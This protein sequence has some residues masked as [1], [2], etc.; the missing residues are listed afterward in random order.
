MN[1]AEFFSLFEQYL[2]IIQISIAKEDIAQIFSEIDRDGDQWIA[3]AEFLEFLKIFFRRKQTRISINIGTSTIMSFAS[4]GAVGETIGHRRRAKVSNRVRKDVNSQWRNILDTNNLKSSNGLTELIR[5]QLFAIILRLDRERSFEQNKDA[6]TRLLF[7]IF[8]KGSGE[9]EFAMRK[10]LKFRK[11]LDECLTYDEL[12]R[13][14]IE[15]QVG[16]LTLEAFKSKKNLFGTN[17]KINFE[18][19]ASMIK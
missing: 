6:L 3:Y 2:S 16:E 9:V 12:V 17:F 13:F 1:Q 18:D 5:N 10:V 8:E 14:L 4:E 15:I 19:F 7:E 11:G